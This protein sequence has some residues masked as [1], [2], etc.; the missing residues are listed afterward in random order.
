MPG[1]C[2]LPA[3]QVF[4][5]FARKTTSP[6]LLRLRVETVFLAPLPSPLFLRKNRRATV[7]LFCLGML[8]NSA[9]LKQKSV[10][11]ADES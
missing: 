10:P 1:H 11:N 7:T 8:V 6:L 9:F 2:G 5:S 4:A 3:L